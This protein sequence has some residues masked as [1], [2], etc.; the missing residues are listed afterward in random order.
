MS[1]KVPFGPPRV[2]TLSPMLIRDSL[3]TEVDKVLKDLPPDKGGMAEVTVDLERG[4]NLVYAYRDPVKG[5]TAAA[6]VGR[7]WDGPI[8][9]GI[10]VR[11]VW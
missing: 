3:K 7:H 2:V 10:Q 1:D 5:W 4:I 9:G 11:K 6:Y 8:V